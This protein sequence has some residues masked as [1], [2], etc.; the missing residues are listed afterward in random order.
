AA[1]NRLYL[2][3]V[4]KPELGGSHYHL[5]TGQ[6]GGEPPRVDVETAP[7][8]FRALHAAIAQ[9]LVRSCHDLSEGG[10]A[11][12]AA[13]MA[14]AGGVGADLK[15]SAG[16]ELSDAVWLFSESATRFLVEVTPEQSA[17]F[18]L[19]FTGLPLANVGQT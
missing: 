18:E 16:D 2:V 10:L 4:T 11:V 13:E 17:A 15:R 5:V 9:G 3:G 14:F 12:A 1:G 6:D 19:C 8:I 7:R